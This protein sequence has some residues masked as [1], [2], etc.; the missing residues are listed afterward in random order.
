M[1]REAANDK[2]IKIIFSAIIEMTPIGLLHPIEY[3][4]ISSCI[5]KYIVSRSTS[6]HFLININYLYNNNHHQESDP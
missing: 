2:F 1:W 4:H 5:L 6:S 3:I